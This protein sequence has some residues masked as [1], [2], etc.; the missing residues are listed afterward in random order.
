MDFMYV[1]FYPT[2]LMGALGLVFGVLLALASVAFFVKLSMANPLFIF[3]AKTR[4]NKLTDSIVST[5]FK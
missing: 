3:A 1:L 5:M 2:A 4:T